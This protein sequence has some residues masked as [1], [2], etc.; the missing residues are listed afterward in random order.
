ML[1][2]HLK[3]LQLDVPFFQPKI[4]FSSLYLKQC[5]LKRPIK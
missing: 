2:F 1:Q 4:E 3:Q 5:N